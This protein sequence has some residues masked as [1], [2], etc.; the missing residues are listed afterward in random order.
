VPR[1]P[2]LSALAFFCLLLASLRC[3]PPVEA[4]ALSP[5][6]RW[7]QQYLRLDTTNP[8]GNEHLGAAFLERVLAR[9]GIGSRLVVTA[10]GRTNLWARLRAQPGVDGPALLLL[11]HIDVVAPGPGWTH[12][13]FAGE[14]RGG[15]L[16]GRGALDAKSLGIAQ[17]AAL[18]DL[19]TSGEALQRDVVL[20]AVADEERGGAEG[21]S[22]LLENHPELFAGVEGVLNE[23]GSNRL[24]NGRLLWWGVEAAQKRPLWLE[25]SVEGRG[26]HGA[27]YNPGSATHQL[28]QGLARVLAR[29]PRWRVTPAARTYL[30]SLAP[31]HGPRWQPLLTDPDRFIGADGP[32][33]GAPV[34]P[35]MQGL[36]LDTVQ[37]TVLEA[38]E[39][40][41]V[42]ASRAVA[43]LDVRLLPDTDADA[44]LS[45]L[46]KTLGEGFDVEV[47]V[48]A[49]PAPPSPTD[50]A[51]HRALAEVLSAEAPVVPVFAPGFTDSRLFRYRGIP[52][53]GF[54][55]FTLE[56]QDLGGIH[57][58]DEGIP[59]TELDRG[60]ERL[61]RVVRRWALQPL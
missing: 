14:V 11:H 23:G 7:L 33:E 28:V 60:I 10:N 31:L 5:A 6:A 13:P 24:V 3:E 52:A 34:M 1:R 57:A 9:H 2:L 48:T 21:A 4:A 43:R 53:Y 47:L 25:V 17:V 15:K 59:V 29:P 32:R 8:P 49:P 61:R 18:V 51:V 50:S 19:A 45:D 40:V 22:W 39:A 54:S 44:F 12:P 37:V 26:G 27:G 16:Y 36:F 20:L 56:P 38:A 41:N 58:A 55:P 42:V 46:R 35:G 30:R